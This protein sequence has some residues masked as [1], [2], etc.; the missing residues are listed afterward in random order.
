[1]YCTRRSIVRLVARRQ[2][3]GLINTETAVLPTAHVLDHF[4]FDLVLGQVEGK[5]GF[6][7]GRFQP[8]QVE[9]ACRNSLRSS[10]SSAVKMTKVAGFVL[11]TRRCR[12]VWRVRENRVP[13]RAACHGIDYE[14]EHE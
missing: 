14:H 2:E 3:Y 4:R 10:A 6:L 13:D 1:M 11:H 9:L 12:P 5:N 8:I 7:P